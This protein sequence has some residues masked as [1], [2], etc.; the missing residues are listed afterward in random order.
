MSVASSND[1][2]TALYQRASAPE[3]FSEREKTLWAGIVDVQPL[4]WFKAGD[5]PLLVAYVRAIAQHERVSLKAVDAELIVS[6]AHGGEQVNP[7]F[8]LQDTLARQMAT[9]AGKLRLSQSAKWT[10]QKA[11]TKDGG[12]GAAKKPWQV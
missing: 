4:D 12:A 5:L 11:A 1:K 6:G 2:I 3:E 9:L 7:I 8:R 10:E